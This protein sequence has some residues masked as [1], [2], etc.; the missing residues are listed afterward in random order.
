MTIDLQKALESAVMGP[1]SPAQPEDTVQS[2]NV[3]SLML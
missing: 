1:E 2:G 3:S